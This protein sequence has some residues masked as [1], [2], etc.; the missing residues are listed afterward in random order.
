M[1]SVA[2]N[3]C[4]IQDNP[5]SISYHQAW[6]P[7]LINYSF[8]NKCR[9]SSSRWLHAH[10]G[11]IPSTGLCGSSGSLIQLFTLQADISERE[12]LAVIITFISRAAEWHINGRILLSAPAWALDGDEMLI[13]GNVYPFKF[14][15]SDGNLSLPRLSS[16]VRRYHQGRLFLA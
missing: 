7:L 5:S 3:G 11:V 16:T 1:Y 13:C 15:A 10:Q 8:I 2:V 9:S 12:T 4:A 6:L 14:A